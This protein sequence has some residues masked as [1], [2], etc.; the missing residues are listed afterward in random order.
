[1]RGS[2]FFEDIRQIDIEIGGQPSKAPIFYYDGSSMTAVFPARYSRLRE[3][4]PNPRYV[5]ARLAPGLGAVAITCLDYRD[6]DVGAYRELAI[7]IP[8]NEPRFRANLPG[9]ALVSA[10]RLGQLHAFIRHLPVTT[11]VA[12]RGG[13]DFYNF[14][15]FIAEID[16]TETNQDLRCRLAEGKE[17]ILTLS[18]KRIATPR[19][20]RTDQFSHLWMDGQPQAAQFKVNQLQVGTSRRPDAAVLTLGER[21]PVALELGRLL[22]WRKP[23]QYEHAPRFEAILFGPEHLTLPLVQRALQSVEALEQHKVSG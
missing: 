10:A 21:H 7:A 6:T 15:K 16:F 8:L 14:P 18:G 11:E 4:M 9:R 2:S 13:I 3:L 22:A 19:R 20:Q 5:P 1:M 12:L 23:L 17:H